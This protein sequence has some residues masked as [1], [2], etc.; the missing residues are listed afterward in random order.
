MLILSIEKRWKDD[1]AEIFKKLDIDLKIILLHH[2]IKFFYEKL[3]HDEQCCK[4]F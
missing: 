1:F 3:K 2:Q 4:K